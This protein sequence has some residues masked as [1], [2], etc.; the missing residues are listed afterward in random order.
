MSSNRKQASTAAQAAYHPAVGAPLAT[1][2]SIT[3][4][5]SVTEG[6]CIPIP[7]RSNLVDFLQQNQADNT[8]AEHADITPNKSDKVLLGFNNLG[9]FFD[10]L[11]ASKHDDELAQ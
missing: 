5:H 8:A 4:P 2:H 9:H 1:R 7:E 11:D 10:W 3:P 6:F